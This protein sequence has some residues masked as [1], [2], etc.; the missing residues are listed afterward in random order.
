[1]AVKVDILYRNKSKFSLYVSKAF[2]D[3]VIA[4]SPQPNTTL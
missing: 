1:M 4:I 2:E 3:N